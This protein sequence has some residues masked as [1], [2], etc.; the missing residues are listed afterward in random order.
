MKQQGELF[1]V[2]LN[3]V[4]R[5]EHNL[6]MPRKFALRQMA[7]AYGVT[8]EWLL[9]ESAGDQPPKPLEAKYAETDIEQQLLRMFRQLP[10]PQQHKV[11]GYI[12]RVFLEYAAPDP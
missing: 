4:Y 11:L 9:D 1:G 6:A 5:W 7:E 10:V 3:S 8:V 2:S 12:E